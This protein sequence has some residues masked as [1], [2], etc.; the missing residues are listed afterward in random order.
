MRCTIEEVI[1]YCKKYDL[2][3]RE[4]DNDSRQLDRKLFD[5]IHLLVVLIFCHIRRS[6]HLR[7]ETRHTLS[8]MSH[9]PN[10]LSWDQDVAASPREFHETDNNR[11]NSAAL[12]ANWQYFSFR[13]I[14]FLKLLSHQKLSQIILSYFS[15]ALSFEKGKR[16][17]QISGK[18]LS[19]AKMRNKKIARH[20]E[21]HR[22]V[23][24]HW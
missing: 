7:F 13:H 24:S 9:K 12:L 3:N 14:W 2:V 21:K 6:I 15:N 8:S 5:L 16:S 22:C 17:F 19:F 20:F 11:T 4:I 1:S 10:L 18:L 23:T